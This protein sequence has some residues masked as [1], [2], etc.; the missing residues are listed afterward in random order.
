LIPAVGLEQTL[1]S[2]QIGEAG[3][4]DQTTTSLYQRHWEPNIVSNINQPQRDG[5]ES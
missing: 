4:E 5:R 1:V 2:R 3:V